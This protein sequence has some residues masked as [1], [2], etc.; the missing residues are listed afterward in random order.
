[1]ASNPPLQVEDQTDEDFFDKL[2][3]D[4]DE[5]KVNETSAHSFG[6]G[7][8][9]D[10]VK[11]F[12]NLSIGEVVTG[13][14]DSSCEGGIEEK[15]EAT[16]RNDNAVSEL[17]TDSGSLEP[18]N[19]FGFDSVNESNGVAKRTE[20]ASESTI[21]KST[22]AVGPGVKEL[23]WTAFNTHSGQIDSNGF[24]SYIDFFS[25]LG[26][27][28]V[29]P[30]GKVEDIAESK[31]GSGSEELKTIGADNNYNNVQYEENQAYQASMGRNEDGQDLN[32]S[33][34]LENLY[35]GWQYDPN[36]GQWYQVDGYDATGNVE[37]SLDSNLAHDLAVPDEN[38]QVSYLQ[39][40][41]EFF[42]GTVTESGATSWSQVPQ[43]N[44]EYPAHMVFDPQY[45]GWYY[46]TIAQEWRSLEMYS[47]S[48]QSTIQAHDHLN[49]NGFASAGTVHHEN[50]KKSYG[51]YGQVHTYRAQDVC[52]QNQDS[53]W[54][55]S[56]NNYDQQ[57]LNMWQQ[58]E[59]VCKS[60]A[61]SEFG[62]NQQLENEYS[63]NFSV[64]NHVTQH[65]PYDSR[66]TV[67]FYENVAQN[68]NGFVTTGSQGFVS[69]GNF[70][71]QINRA[72]MQQNEQMH[73]SKDYYGNQNSVNFSQQQF[74]SSNQLSYSPNVGRSSAGRP[75]H[76][77][78]TF[79]FGGKLIVMKEINSLSTSSYG[80]Q[81]PLEGSISV[82]NLME[83]VAEKIDRSGMGVGTF[84]YF[85]TLSK[86]HFPGP[87]V[88][89]SVGSK[90][91]N[92]WIDERIASCES[93]VDYRKGEV[94]RLLLS[95]LK[96]ACQYYGKLRSPF[97]TDIAFRVSYFYHSHAL[98]PI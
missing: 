24:G 4:D 81:G 54:T 3:D 62:G 61:P 53:N 63:R 87:L 19:S 73:A 44:I 36:T 72:N 31:I 40:T 6:D 59:D 27:G 50:D 77:L 48:V 13:S 2:V 65:K 38:S 41:S 20:V 79:G 47:S 64:N 94:L 92:K 49:Q 51:Y 15:G 16:P 66:G 98:L 42:V 96:I 70:S 29:D 21:S 52:A 8:D 55:G 95:L 93:T 10:E 68:Q 56:F 22:G 34:Y 97:G 74:Q 80:S 30:P 60:E 17:G 7:N 71:Q 46:D 58:P 83:V 37:G 33:Q 78:V 45:P 12:A 39:Q 57:G 1:M 23:Q 28:A 69:S 86:Q 18:S 25:E 5:F 84:D 26:D 90:E 75:P 91:L 76:A 88:G 85:N 89:G 9:S 35:P 82:L 32:S 11:A 14:E 43:G 67:Q